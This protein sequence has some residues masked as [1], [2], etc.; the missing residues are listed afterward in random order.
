EGGPWASSVAETRLRI[1]DLHIGGCDPRKDVAH[2]HL[3]GRLSI[4]TGRA[5]APKYDRVHRRAIVTTHPPAGAGTAA[6]AGGSAA[7]AGDDEL[8]HG[9]TGRYRYAHNRATEAV[10][11]QRHRVRD[12]G[13]SGPNLRRLGRSIPLVEQQ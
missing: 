6:G 10:E 12:R 9:G 3:V 13:K 7:V 2:A 11:T 1:H 5:A 4:G 8:R